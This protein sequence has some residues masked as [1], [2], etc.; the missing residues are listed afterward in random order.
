MAFITAGYV[1]AAAM[2]DLLDKDGDEDAAEVARNV[3]F[4]SPEALWFCDVATQY[5]F[6]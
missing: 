6:V 1:H 3:D 4:D 5:L 2:P